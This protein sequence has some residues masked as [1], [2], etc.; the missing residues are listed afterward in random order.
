MNEDMVFYMGNV[1][2]VQHFHFIELLFLYG[3]YYYIVHYKPF[4]TKI[5]KLEKYG[6]YYQLRKWVRKCVFI[7][8]IVVNK[9]IENAI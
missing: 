3:M 4:S 9:N 2:N 7:F 1:I 6:N 5:E 8:L